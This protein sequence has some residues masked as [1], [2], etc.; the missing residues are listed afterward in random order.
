MRCPTWRALACIAFGSFSVSVFAQSPLTWT[1][2]RERFRRNNPSLLAG[3]TFVEESRANEITASL[4]PNPELSLI[5][6]QFRL[7]HPNPLQPFQNTQITPTITELWERRRKRQLRTESARFA[8]SIVQADL[9]DQERQLTFALRDAFIRTLQAKS[10]VELAEANL[11]YYDK[12]IGVNR[13]RYKAGDVSKIDLAR[14]ELQR[15]QFET[16]VVNARVN[17]RTA[18]IGLLALMNERQPVD[19]FDVTGDFDFHEHILLLDELRQDAIATRPDMKSAAGAIEKAHSDYRLAWA[20]GS[21]DPIAGVEYQRTGP[22]NTLGLNVTI[23]LRIFDR[24]QGEK[25]RT[26]LEIRRSEQ[27]RESLVAGIYRDV[28][29]AYATFDSVIGLLRPY[30]SQY[31]QQSKEIRDSIEYAFSKGAAS[32]LDFLDAQKS[33]RDTQ[34]NYRNLIASYLSAANQL[35]LAVGREVIP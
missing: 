8:T 17:L 9:T 26:S 28:D 30:R 35:N 1:E 32:L 29:S 16:D 20:N 19:G 31:L 15:V 21:T 14:V 10:L 13:E 23:P 24:N 11:G 3:Q 6:D 25:A 27:L 33:Y 18:K 7:F 34:L 22:D 12:V 5:A 2:I 4:R